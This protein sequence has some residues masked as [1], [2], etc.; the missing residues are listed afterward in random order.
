M[1]TIEQLEVLL[2]DDPDD[3]FLNFGLAMALR[4]A[5]RNEEAL[6]RFD[7]T[8]A[9]DPN[10]VSAHHQKGLL[11]A[12]LGRTDEARKALERGVEAAAA[13]GDEHVRTKLTELL[14]ALR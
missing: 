5:E 12:R 13:L 2:E 3:V 4:S 8:L 14:D 7:R 11:L 9:L 6:E 10:Y 1:P